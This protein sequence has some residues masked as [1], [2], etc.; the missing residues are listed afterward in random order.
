MK[1]KLLLFGLAMAI[2]AISCS[3]D[4]DSSANITS[5]EV[6]ANQK[7]DD[8]IDDVSVIADDQYEVREGTASGRGVQDYY[9]ILPACASVSDAGST[10][11]IRIL[12][13]T[14]GTQTTACLFR[15]HFLKGK[16]IITRT[17]TT[18]FPK[19]MTITYDGFYVDGNKLE[20]EMTWSREMVGSG[21][22]LHPKTTLTMTNVKL[23][24]SDGAYVRNGHRT[25]EMIEGFPTR[26]SPTDD[27][28][29]TYGEFSTTFPNGDVYSSYISETTPL[30]H[31]NVCS[32]NTPPSPYPVSG[33]L[34]LSKNSHHN[35]IDYGDGDCDNL[36]MLSIDGGV[37]FQITLGD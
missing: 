32:L 30:L 10:S 4:D 26:N 9:S 25:T 12:T 27:Q 11:A 34:V 23:T 35:S 28:F 17:I 2:I 6:I 31:K 16:V 13:I 7:M 22:S 15:G 21:I 37:A 33:I 18:T 29:I 1:T 8:A 14:F 24:T 19:T 3:K 20:G 5:S 36:A